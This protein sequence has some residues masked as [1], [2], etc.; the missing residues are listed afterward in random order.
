MPV[1]YIKRK[2]K[3][4]RKFWT[5]TKCKNRY[6]KEDDGCFEITEIKTLCENCIIKSRKR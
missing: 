6:K 4:P 2:I 3:K 1:E 5:C